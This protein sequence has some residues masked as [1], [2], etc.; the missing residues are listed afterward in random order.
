MT[1]YKKAC[2]GIIS[3][4]ILALSA[5]GNSPATVQVGAKAQKIADSFFSDGSGSYP[6]WN[7]T[8]RGALAA[9]VTGTDNDDFFNITFGEFFSEYMYHL[10]LYHI[11]DDMSDANKAVCEGYRDSIITYMTFERMYLYTAEKEYGISESTLT[12]AQKKEIRD[13]ADTV[14]KNSASVFY[15][16]AS[17]MLGENADESSIDKL[18]DEV[19]EAVL[20]KCGLDS[21]VFYKWE[22]IRYIEELMLTEA[23]KTSGV[24]DADVEAAY[25]QFLGAAKAEAA[26]DPAGYDKNTA[27]MSVFVPEGTRKADYIYLK[28]GSDKNSA[29]AAAEEIAVKLSAGGS[30][31]AIAEKYPG[32]A[33][34]E[35]V[36]ILRESSSYPE[37]LRN[38]LYSLNNAGEVSE[39]TECGDGV[40][41]VRF[42]GDAEISSEATEQL[43]NDLRAQL[44]NNKEN[45]VQSR[46]YSEWSEKYNYTINYD[47]LKLT[48]G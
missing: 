12:D 27:Y 46:I 44:E 14:R 21:D 1:R 15:T 42:T 25:G 30:L 6:A 41:I 23:I 33:V 37:E 48:A 4:V 26:K 13:T 43:K 29:A 45:T 39:P 34:A 38:A 17:S 18:C 7:D 3:A 32:A 10:V 2:A 40:Y 31:S 35:D 5:C 19:L 9:Y 20:R 8:D 47:L 16:S 22:M 11:D 36:T 28:Y 24:T